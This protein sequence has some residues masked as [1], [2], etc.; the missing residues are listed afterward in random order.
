MSVDAPVSDVGGQPLAVEEQS[1]LTRLQFLYW[2][3]QVMRPNVPFLNT[4]VTF[5]VMGH[6][7]VA[8]FRQAFQYLVDTSDALRTLIIED[9]GVPQRI[10]QDSF[11]YALPLIDFSMEVEPDLS[12]A[13]WLN[14][15]IM[16]P[17][18]INDGLFDSALVKLA[19]DQFVWYFN[20]HHIMADASSFFVA[21]RV[22]AEAYEALLVGN[23]AALPKRPLFQSYIDYERKYRESARFTK[24]GQY[25]QQ[26]L[27][28]GPDPLRFHG[29]MPVKKSTHVTR[30]SIELGQ[31]LSAQLR[32]VAVRKE[33][34][35]INIDLSL[36]NIFGA[37]FFIHLQQMTQ[38]RLLGAV[39]PVHNRLTEAYRETIGLFMELCPMQVEIAE[40]D[41]FESVIKKMR[42]ETRST[43]PHY[44][45]GSSLSLQS[46]TFD[47]MFNMH[48]M[49]N[50][51][52]QGMSVAYTKVQPGHGS[53]GFACHVYDYTEA[54]HFVVHLDCHDDLFTKEEREETAVTFLTLVQSFLADSTQAI[55]PTF[56]PLDVGKNEETA[57][58]ANGSTSTIGSRHRYVAPRDA[59]ENRMA[60]I[61]EELLGITNIGIH[62]NFFDIGG[63]SWLATRL[64]VRIQEVTGHNLPL[65]TL[66]EAATVA[67]MVMVMREQSEGRLW[68]PIVTLKVGDEGKR[69]FFFVP[70]AGGNLLRLDKMVG[71]IDLDRRF[72]AFQVPGLEGEIEPYTTIEDM[73]AHFVGVMREIQPHG[74]YILGGYSWGGMIAFEMAQ[75]LHKKE[76]AVEFLAIIDTPAQH[77]NY[78]YLRTLL[79]KLGWL[80][81]WKKRKQEKNFLFV[82]DYLFRLEYFVRA[83]YHEFK[84]LG[85]RE[86]KTVLTR[87][88]KTAG[89]KLNTAVT[90]KPKPS[91]QQ[92][93]NRK[94]E[95]EDF[96]TRFNLDPLRLRIVRIND[97]SIRL[98]IPQPY[99]G[100][101]F[102]FQSSEG[103]RNPL[104]RSAAPELGWGHCV[105]GGVESQSIP[106]D[107][108][109]ML[110]EPNVRVLAEKL[111]AALDKTIK[112]T[113]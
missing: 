79:T 12:Y 92:P 88:L 77:P 40:D 54:G 14:E 93:P 74:P 65:S 104:N 111:Q 112:E 27:T 4:V 63:S 78:R 53:E 73:A 96:W 1:N 30:V 15:Q 97:R 85:L 46:E 72:L 20:Q 109:G 33:L 48:Q 57:V 19:E 2:V 95:N 99:P 6:L 90:P 26:K 17:I 107:H 37:L 71:M 67:G 24:S 7:D 58:S 13:A 108:L 82:R 64:F 3:A 55:N 25:W 32:E 16:V 69:P 100:K 52:F 39:T 35:T 68:S 41:T 59:M 81:G 94:P 86:K 28:P 80:L 70:G 11:V 51:E 105:L 56:A 75:Q 23:A 60:R 84:D 44:Q 106:G 110:E 31:E 98:Y 36:Y 38:N 34:F 29:K 102:L 83:G 18:R 22:V 91:Q 47:T 89:Q 43:M 101:L 62:D 61:W 50:L 21:F 113:I 9:N 45:N 42:R 5:K 49:P 76:E 8:L 66:L 10:V 103:Y 87:K